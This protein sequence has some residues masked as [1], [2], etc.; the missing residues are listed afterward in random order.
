MHVWR[1]WSGKFRLLSNSIKTAQSM[2]S[3]SWRLWKG[4][5]F[6]LILLYRW[7][8]DA[9]RIGIEKLISKILK[10]KKS[11]EIKSTKNC[12]KENDHQGYLIVME[13]RVLMKCYLLS[14]QF[15]RSYH[16]SKY[17]LIWYTLIVQCGPGAG[18]HWFENMYLLWYL[19]L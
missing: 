8:N 11:N 17:Q 2:I 15:E 14:R 3:L 12:R 18:L 9:L 19:A 16:G 13:I 7:S 1:S 6:I 5:L 4:D 10:H